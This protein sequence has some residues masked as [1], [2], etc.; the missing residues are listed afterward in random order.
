MDLVWTHTAAATGTLLLFF[1]DYHSQVSLSVFFAAPLLVMKY[2]FCWLGAPLALSLGSSAWVAGVSL[3]LIFIVL[4]SAGLCG[5]RF[6][7]HRKIA[8]AFTAIGCYAVLA[9]AATALGRIGLKFEW[10]LS[11]RYT[12][13]S[14]YL[15][16]GVVGLA[17][18]SFA[19]FDERDVPVGNRVRKL[20]SA[21][22]V[23]AIFMS[24]LSTYRRGMK[25]MAGTGRHR[26]QGRAALLFSEVLPHNP[27]LK[28]LSPDPLAM[29]RQYRA[30]LRCG[31]ARDAIIS[32]RSI[33]PLEPRA[34]VDRSHGCLT[35][36]DVK[37]DHLI[38]KGWA[39]REPR[40]PAPFVLFAYR[41]PDRPAVPF[42]VSSTG[43]ST[44]WLIRHGFR[45]C[46]F[47]VDLEPDLPSGRL[48]ISAWDDGSRAE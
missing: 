40:K 22:V 16:I 27:D 1:W 20:A 36:C 18:L 7:G 33:P 28:L 37:G 25:G 15:P 2:F 8:Y 13:F 48:E 31:M 12:T 41:A 34:E 3:L 23:I 24:S 17:A 46:G 47:T 45:N 26:A 6:G 30:L 32:P 39:L 35:V 43:D 10:A 29:I 44:P 42:A 14:I 4:S 5:P 38:M 11:S 9:G 19:R 21:L